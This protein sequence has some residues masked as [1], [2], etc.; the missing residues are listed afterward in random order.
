M[1]STLTLDKSDPDV[2][3][4]VDGWA[5]DTEYTV[6]MTIRTGAGDKRNVATVESVEE[7]EPEAPDDET[8]EPAESGEESPGVEAVKS[9]MGS[10][11]K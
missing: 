8:A 6:T 10:M 1:A 4:L 3:K 9:A 2:K 7:Q 11:A 5:D